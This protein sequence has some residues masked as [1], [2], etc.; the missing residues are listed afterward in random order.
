MYSDVCKGSKVNTVQ[1][2]LLLFPLLCFIQGW[3]KFYEFSMADLRAGFEII[4][5]LFEGRRADLRS[6]RL[7]C[8]TYMV[9]AT[10]ICRFFSPLPL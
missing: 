4:D 10:V 2:S 6:A 1:L 7:L 9:M 5:R 8:S 3:T